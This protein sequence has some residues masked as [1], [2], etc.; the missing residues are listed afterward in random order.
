MPLSAIPLTHA[1]NSTAR[2]F[3]YSSDIEQEPREDD[4][5]APAESEWP[6]EGRVK[7]ENLAVRYGRDKPEVLHDVSFELRP[8]Q[9]VGCCGTSGSGKSTI[10]QALLRTLETT[11]GRITIDGRDIADVPLETLRSRITL[12]PQGACGSS[13]NA[14]DRADPTLFAGTVRSNLD[15]KGEHDDADLWRVLEQTGFVHE[16]EHDGSHGLDA[17]IASGGSNLSLGLRQLL[18]LSRAL[19]RKSKLVIMVRTSDSWTKLTRAGRSDGVDRL[20]D[21]S[22]DPEGCPRGLRS[23]HASHHRPCVGVIGAAL[24]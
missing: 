17:T 1:V 14:A 22:A 5:D 16:N 13:A 20:Q 10:S 2:V 6:T 9:S 24:S 12:I 23:R 3:E 19:L 8:G 4:K 7:I 18:C 21:R 15:V 11:H